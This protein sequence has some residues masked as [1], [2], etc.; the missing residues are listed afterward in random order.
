MIVAVS[1]KHIHYK[2][3]T[4]YLPRRK[5]HVLVKVKKKKRGKKYVW[6]SQPFIQGH[7]ACQAIEWLIA[8]LLFLLLFL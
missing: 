6:L 2:F 3:L 5:I 1:K 4:M 8:P 7:E